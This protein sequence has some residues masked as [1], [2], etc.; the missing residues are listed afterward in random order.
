[1]RSHT[2]HGPQQRSS[3]T[4]EVILNHLVKP[5]PGHVSLQWCVGRKPADPALADGQL[6]EP[7]PIGRNLEYHVLVQDLLWRQ[8]DDNFVLG[9][10]VTL[11]SV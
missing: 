6:P 4:S 3:I 9:Q 7:V 5:L 1:M 8:R 10:E 2:I 11:L